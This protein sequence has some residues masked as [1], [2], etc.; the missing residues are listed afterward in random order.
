MFKKNTNKNEKEKEKLKRKKQPNKH[1]K[2]AGK[3]GLEATRSFP[4]SEKQ[5]PTREPA[6]PVEL[7]F[8]SN[9]F[10]FYWPAHI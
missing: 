4:E 1:I 3:T 2:P 8:T 5:K 10:Y 9:S 7:P 6:S